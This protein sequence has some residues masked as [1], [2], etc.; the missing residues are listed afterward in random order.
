LIKI[1]SFRINSTLNSI[2]LGDWHELNLFEVMV[3]QCIIIL[4]F[5]AVE[6]AVYAHGVDMQWSSVS[7][8]S[9]LI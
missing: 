9:A 3:S 2:L 7:S 6:A 8:I 4:L 1:V 5:T